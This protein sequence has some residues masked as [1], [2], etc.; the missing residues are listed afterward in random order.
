M[1][2]KRSTH[3]STSPPDPKW[4]RIA[5]EIKSQEM[6]PAGVEAADAVAAVL[7]ALA[8]RLSA[9]E[10]RQLIDALPFWLGPMLRP[11][12]VHFEA[13]APFARGEFLARVAEHLQVESEAAG[14]L[15]GAV[16]AAVRKRLPP[17]E[18]NDVR[19]QL[20]QEL[21]EW[22]GPPAP[23]KAAAGPDAV[24]AAI[25]GEIE[26]R[27][28][29]GPD[30]PA[31]DGAA[32]VL[33][34]LLQRLPGH[35]ARQLMGELPGTL[36]AMLPPCA[37]HYEQPEGFGRD[38]FF[39]RVRQ[40]V[41]VGEEATGTLARTVLAAVGEHLS[42][43]TIE[44]VAAQLPMELRAL[45]GTS[46]PAWPPEDPALAAVLRE[47]EGS[48]ALPP[49]ISAAD[50]AA[51]ILCVLAERLSRGEAQHLA[52]LVPVPLR[53][54]MRA[55]AQHLEEPETFDREEFLARVSRR[56]RVDRRAAEEI[57]RGVLAAVRKQ[58]P[59]EEVRHVQGQLPKEL[60]ELWAPAVTV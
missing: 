59:A 3:P 18:I 44:R 2:E 46:P 50:A 9:G 6:L 29:L 51:G 15:T 60:E 37:L 41:P 57:T 23:L 30:I 56:L 54:T 47:L 24:S 52:A 12:A 11:C 8:Q 33:C 58:L 13:A 5:R 55:C 31:A 53:E 21:R 28:V 19:T 7:C 4:E 10:A 43:E 48:G 45:W 20:P 16:F 35:L 25:F 14:P 42:P 34:V 26:R 1:A 38:G 27:E 36:R 17:K 39:Q 22:W 40:A 49:K 32:A